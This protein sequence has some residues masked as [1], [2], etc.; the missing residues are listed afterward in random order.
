MKRLEGKIALITGGGGGIGAATGQRLTDEGAKVVL[1]DIN[2]EWAQAAADRIGH[3]ATAVAY[4]A[5]D[6]SSIA[7]MVA[8]T[9]ERHGTL[10]ILHN[11]AALTDPAIGRQDTTA[12]D[13]PLDIWDRIMA[14]NLRGYLAASKYAI[15][16]MLKKGKGAIINTASGSG[17]VGDLSRIAYGTTK[18]GAMQITRAI[19]TQYGRQGIRC[20]AVAP[21]L[22]LTEASKKGVPEMLDIIANHV[23]TQR[24][25]Q[26]EDIAAVVA[27]LASD[28]A[29]FIN[30][31]TIRCNGGSLEHQPHTHDLAQFL[32][33]A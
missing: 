15:P 23:L 17:F 30:G 24:L 33:Q 31:E 18:A 21:G 9:V 22:I 16:H 7:A 25:G 29:G 20:N 26:P 4:D 13:I 12:V 32:A 11:N 8:T 28:D 5:E 2:L 1:A 14:V 3:G 6:V 19:A 27:F 10:D